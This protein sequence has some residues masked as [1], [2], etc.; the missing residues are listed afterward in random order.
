[1]KSIAEIF[2]MAPLKGFAV[3]QNLLMK[4]LEGLI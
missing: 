2:I 4:E 1:M 3:Y